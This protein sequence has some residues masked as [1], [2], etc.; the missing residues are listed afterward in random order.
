MTAIQILQWK[1]D[2][3]LKRKKSFY[4]R[5]KR[6]GEESWIEDKLVQYNK[7]DNKTIS[8]I[9]RALKILNCN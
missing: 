5:K 7:E 3:V 2:E 9:R 6:N 8:D 4:R 1:L